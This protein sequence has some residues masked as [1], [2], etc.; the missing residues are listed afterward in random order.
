MEGCFTGQNSIVSLI[1][2][3]ADMHCVLYYLLQSG[4]QAK[5]EIWGS[6]FYLRQLDQQSAAAHVKAYP[7]ILM[8]G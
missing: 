7:H 4:I 1:S 5:H 8:Q 6:S 2:K 3:S